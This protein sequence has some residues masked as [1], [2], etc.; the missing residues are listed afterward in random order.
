MRL[1]FVDTKRAPKSKWSA[2]NA[3]KQ[4]Q[5]Q[6]KPPPPSPLQ[7]RPVPRG[8]F[9]YDEALQSALTETH[10][11]QESH[12]SRA[13]AAGVPVEPRKAAEKILKLRQA[14][15]QTAELKERIKKVRDDRE[16]SSIA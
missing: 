9:D 3:P 15:K 7:P 13:Q 6:P 4:Q 11:Y 12:R 5:P 1:S 8:R 16:Y 14:D 10:D 2:S